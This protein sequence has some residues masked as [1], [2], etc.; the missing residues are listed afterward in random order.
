[1]K[2]YQAMV[3][4]VLLLAT[5]FD[6]CASNTRTKRSRDE[7][8]VVYA[9]PEQINFPVRLALEPEVLVTEERKVF[10][11][12]SVE[13]DQLLE[14]ANRGDVDARDGFVELYFDA[15]IGFTS[16][17]LVHLMGAFDNWCIYKKATIDD[18]Y[19]FFL[20]DLCR[21]DER[22]KETVLYKHR[23]II[24]NVNRRANLGNIKALHNLG[25]IYVLGLV[26]KEPK[27][28]AECF[29]KSAQQNHALSLCALAYMYKYGIGVKQ[30]KA[31]ESFLLSKAKRQGYDYADYALARLEG[32][33]SYA[34]VLRNP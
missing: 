23:D 8:E 6:L 9:L 7:Y 19:A 3:C 11:L 26:G 27:F 31:S 20:I 33:G 15:A 1:M 30:D 12:S 18:Y 16:S 2:F 32:I 10:Q 24:I 28:A 4:G 21:F 29:R 25:Y 5:C 13:R 17:E 34:S 14:N 22:M